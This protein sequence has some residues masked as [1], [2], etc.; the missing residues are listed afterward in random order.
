MQNQSQYGVASIPMVKAIPEAT[1]Q[2]RY[3]K[4]N[5]SLLYREYVTQI[6][7]YVLA[8]VGGQSEAEDITSQ[9]FMEAL[10]RIDKFGKQA[11]Y[12]AWLFTIARNKVIDSYRRNRNEVS[13]EAGSELA[14][15]EANLLSGLI[16]AEERQRLAHLL[17]GLPADQQELL[18]LRFAGELP[19]SQIAQVVRKSEAA[20]KMSIH[21]LLRKLHGQMEESHE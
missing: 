1:S 16:D 11:N 17:A 21:R 10:K 15:G 7:R 9:V 20:V 8:R 13:L 3:T 2:I 19:Y 18:Q 14:T 4:E 12:A 6:Y 5:F